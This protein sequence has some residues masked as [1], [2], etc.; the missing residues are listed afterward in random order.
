MLFPGNNGAGSGLHCPTP[1]AEY[2]WALRYRE[3][4]ATGPSPRPLSGAHAAEIQQCVMDSSC[5][6]PRRCKKS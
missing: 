6:R 1:Q 4:V 2:R 3:P 5:F